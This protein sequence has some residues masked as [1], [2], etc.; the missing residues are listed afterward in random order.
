MQRAA[1][2]SVCVNGPLSCDEVTHRSIK[3]Q[4]W[5]RSKYKVC[6]ATMSTFH[7]FADNLCGTC[8]YVLLT[9]FLS[10]SCRLIRVQSYLHWCIIRRL[11]DVTVTLSTAWDTTDLYYTRYRHRQVNFGTHSFL[12]A[13][14]VSHSFIVFY[15]IYMLLCLT[16]L[17]CVKFVLNIVIIF[18]LLCLC[19]G[20]SICT[21]Q[22]VMLPGVKLRYR[23]CGLDT[24]AILWV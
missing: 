6:P 12:T 21:N 13:W 3:S 8:R 22:A 17:I 11:T 7:R 5:H 20:L 9:S 24:I 15:A 14:T 23:I 1:T 10:T 4:V 19:S 18:C 2:H 16:V